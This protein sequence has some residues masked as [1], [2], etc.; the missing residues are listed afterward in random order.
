MLDDELKIVRQGF[1]WKSGRR[2]GP[3]T[4]KRRHFALIRGYG[5]AILLKGKEGAHDI[6]DKADLRIQLKKRKKIDLLD[7]C[8]VEPWNPRPGFLLATRK[9][10]YE[11]DLNDNILRDGWVADIL[12]VQAGAISQTSRPIV[13]LNR[14]RRDNEKRQTFYT[15]ATI[16]WRREPLRLE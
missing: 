6:L 14:K 12:D 1:V 11:I 4:K 3:Y 2:F 7:G 8:E 5:Y 16:D 15:E 10:K 9:R 13:F